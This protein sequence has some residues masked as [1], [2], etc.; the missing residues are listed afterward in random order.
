MRLWNLTLVSVVSKRVEFRFLLANTKISVQH[1]DNDCQHFVVHSAE[2]P[3][4]YLVNLL[5]SVNKIVI[6]LVIKRIIII[7]IIN[8]SSR[9][10]ITTSKFDRCEIILNIVVHSHNSFWT[11]D[12]G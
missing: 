2:T 7:I 11:C 8:S 6:I 1:I 12:I 10:Y 3:N 5:P 4:L 9:V